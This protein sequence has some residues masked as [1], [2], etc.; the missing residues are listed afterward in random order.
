MC[1]QNSRPTYP[2]KI[3]VTPAM[4]QAGVLE[5]REAVFGGSMV[6]IVEA[7]YYAMETQ[8]LADDLKEPQPR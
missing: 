6:E 1:V 3:K 7:I 5:L 2:L 8:R 4:V